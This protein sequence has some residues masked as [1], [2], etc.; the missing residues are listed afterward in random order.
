MV[1]ALATSRNP[2]ESVFAKIPLKLAVFVVSYFLLVL[3]QRIGFHPNG[4]QIRRQQP[5][6]PIVT[7]PLSDHGVLLGTSPTPRN[8]A[9][10][11][12]GNIGGGGV[13][14]GRTCSFRVK[15]SS[16]PS[17]GPTEC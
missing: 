9:I 4:P 8:A 11:L 14:G 17:S 3:S 5:R 16:R 12:V 1:F 13:L 2:E 6:K 15:S 7:Y 10:P